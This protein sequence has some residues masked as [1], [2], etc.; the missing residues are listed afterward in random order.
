MDRGTSKEEKPSCL[1]ESESSSLH[2]CA[3]W[4]PSPEGVLK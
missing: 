1:C 2:V 3:L 4:R